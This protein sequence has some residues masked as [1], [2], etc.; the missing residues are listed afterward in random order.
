MLNENVILEK[1]ISDKT[2]NSHTVV[3][4]GAG[5]FNQLQYVNKNVKIK[6]G[7]EI[8]LPYI[9]NA[10]YNDCIKIQG[11]ILNYNNLLKE[12]ELDTVMLCDVLEHFVM[13]DGYDLISRL[14]KDFNKILLMLPYGV[15]KQEND[16]TGYGADEYQQHKSY[17]FKDDIEKLEFDD[18]ILDLCFQGNPLHVCYFGV[19]YK[20]KHLL[21]N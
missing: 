17:W 15:H 13:N 4:L 18:D 6:I 19:W 20:N 8:W 5:F 16:I 9:V 21:K 11:D 7:I 14:K 1:W 12:Y 2:L 3:E 10:T